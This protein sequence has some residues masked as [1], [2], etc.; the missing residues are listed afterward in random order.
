MRFLRTFTQ[1]Q[2]RY[3]LYLVRDDA[4]QNH[5]PRQEVG[6]YSQFLADVLCIDL[7]VIG[8]GM[9]LPICEQRYSCYHKKSDDCEEISHDHTLVG[10]LRSES[11]SGACRT[12]E[13]S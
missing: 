13:I 7:K 12:Q 2:I 8:A 1:N 10:L 5:D 9:L 3:L 6:D 4:Q 11:H